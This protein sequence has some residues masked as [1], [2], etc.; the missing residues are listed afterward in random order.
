ML[1]AGDKITVRNSKQLAQK[2]LNLLTNRTG[3]VTKTLVSQGR[4]LGAYAD[5]KVMRRVK[6]YYI[7]IE[8]IE[9]PDS[10]NR[11]RTLSLLKA[12]VL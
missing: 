7:P 3:V 6:N 9:G 10:V 12:T 11:V 1:K 2:G 5:I 8:S 4:I